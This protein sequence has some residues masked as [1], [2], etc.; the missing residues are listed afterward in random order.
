MNTSDVHPECTQAFDQWSESVQQFLLQ[1][2]ELQREESPILA[3]YQ[4]NLSWCVLTNLRLIWKNPDEST[5]QLKLDDIERVGWSS[6]PE[7]SLERDPIDPRD[8]LIYIKTDGSTVKG[9]CGVHS[10][11]LHLIDSN[12][13]RHEVFL[14]KGNLKKIKN[15][16]WRMSGGSKRAFKLAQES[17]QTSKQNDPELGSDAYK[18]RRLEGSLRGYEDVYSSSIFKALSSE[19]QNYFLSKGPFDENELLVYG[20]FVNEETWFLATT[21]R[22]MWS[23]PGF[24]CRLGYDK[25]FRIGMSDLERIDRSDPDQVLEAKVSS[26]WLYFEDKQGQR[27]EA[28]VP[29]GSTLNAIWNSMLFMVQLEKIHPAKR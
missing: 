11:W 12:G 14:E 19:I 4:P 26:P 28:L 24:T 1:Q 3:C 9:P 27:H 6:G 20:Y 16:I 23:R 7:G 5:H 13:T 8:T 22:A 15:V 29:C 2:T 10:P 25:I 18:A 17:N 21:R